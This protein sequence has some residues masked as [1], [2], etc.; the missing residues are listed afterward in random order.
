M[1]M[2]LIIHLWIFKDFLQT[3]N[4]QDKFLK[5]SLGFEALDIVEAYTY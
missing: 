2:L 3:D 5:Q 4:N 1:E